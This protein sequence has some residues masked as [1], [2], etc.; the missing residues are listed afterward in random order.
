M[1]NAQIIEGA[2]SSAGKVAKFWM[3]TLCLKF[4]NNGDRND[5]FMLFKAR[6]RAGVCQKDRCIQNICFAR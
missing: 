3:V 4:A 6:H 1:F 5:Y 2:Q